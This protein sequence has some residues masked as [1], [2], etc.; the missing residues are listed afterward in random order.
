MRQ[1]RDAQGSQSD[2]RWGRPCTTPSSSASRCQ[3]Y[4][5][6]SE[7][8]PAG[9][10]HV[11]KSRQ[12]CSVLVPPAAV[13]ELQC[14]GSSP[15]CRLPCHAG[16]KSYAMR[17]SAGNT[18]QQPQFA[19]S[20]LSCAAAGCAGRCRLGSRCL[21]KAQL[22]SRASPSREKVVSEPAGSSVN[23]WQQRMCCS[24]PANK[25]PAHLQAVCEALQVGVQMR[26]EATTP[27]QVELLHKH[28]A[29]RVGAEHCC[30]AS[31]AHTFRRG[32]LR[33]WNPLPVRRDA[34]ARLRCSREAARLPSA[35]RPASVR[36]LACSVRSSAR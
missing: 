8:R 9:K 15:A 17:G 4:C 32:R 13:L 24:G 27:S 29:V 30:S 2:V 33:P 25:P 12:V 28:Q 19:Y 5:R 21:S 36:A 3:Q 7:R 35:G 22:A 23:L 11:S 14:P 34:P 18:L 16:C 26:L 1:K 20:H 10:N 31:M 6:L